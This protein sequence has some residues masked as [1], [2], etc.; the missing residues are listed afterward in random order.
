QLPSVPPEAPP[1]LGVLWGKQHPS[2]GGFIQPPL[3]PMGEPRCHL[4]GH[5]QAPV[6]PRGVAVIEATIDIRLCRPPLPP[7]SAIAV[8][9][10]RIRIAAHA[11]DEGTSH[12]TASRDA[13]GSG[14]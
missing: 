8:D 11:A 2:H 1:T 12:F 4:M 6:G 9:G 3:Q 5:L 14:G 13:C 7:S 10:T